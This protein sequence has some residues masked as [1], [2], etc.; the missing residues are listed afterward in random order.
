M[1][2]FLEQFTPSRH[3]ESLCGVRR[4]HTPEVGSRG[5]G[6]REVTLFGQLIGGN[7]IGDTG[8]VLRQ[9]FYRL[10]SC[11]SN[12]VVSDWGCAPNSNFYLSLTF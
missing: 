1:R 7:K 10:V 11:Q 2:E 3:L 12:R 8:L 9:P 4:D 6:C 5:A